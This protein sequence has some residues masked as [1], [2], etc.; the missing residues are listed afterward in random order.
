MPHRLDSE[1]PCFD[2]EKNP[3]SYPMIFNKDFD[4]NLQLVEKNANK[5]YLLFRK[6][7]DGCAGYAFIVCKN[8]EVRLV[9]FKIIFDSYSKIVRSYGKGDFKEV[10]LIIIAKRFSEEVINFISVYN[11]NYSRRT[12]IRIFV[13]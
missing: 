3:Y 4:F 8:G 2:L 1:D 6:N 12:P 10:E 9:D 5:Q 13:Y 11:E 7:F